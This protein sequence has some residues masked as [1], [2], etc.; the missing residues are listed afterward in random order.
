MK[1]ITIGRDASCNICINDERISRRHALLK[2]YDTGKMEIVDMSSNGTYVNG[3]KLAK[4][5]PF[6]V[7]RKN[8]V[9]FG[10]AR[11]LDW[12]DIPD[13]TK[14]IKI[15][16]L[17][18]LG[19]VV[20]TAIVMF[21]VK[22]CNKT[23]EYYGE[24]SSPAVE[25]AEVK[26]PSGLNEENAS[27]ESSSIKP[28]DQEQ[29]VIQP[30]KEKASE[31]HPKDTTKKKDTWYNREIQKDAQRKAAAMKAK[32]DSAAQATQSKKKAEKPT[33]QQENKKVTVY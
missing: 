6:P 15:V 26:S 24:S 11:Q 32:K 10:H 9:V 29:D 8:N 17:S 20:I 13:P 18:V 31:S 21:F 4:N 33:T 30:Q 22:S 25:N 7:T 3:I 27:N 19:L 28:N 14:P 1:T 5:V 16:A 23:P 2:I 12:N